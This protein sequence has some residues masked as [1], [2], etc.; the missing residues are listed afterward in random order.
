ML[1]PGN[2]GATREM[3]IHKEYKETG[4]NKRLV[5]AGFS[6]AHIIHS[7]DRT[8]Q[9]YDKLSTYEGPTSPR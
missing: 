2:F 3:M 1:M 5:R 4:Q 7:L 8:L 6:I 9:L